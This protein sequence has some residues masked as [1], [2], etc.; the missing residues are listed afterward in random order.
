[1]RRDAAGLRFFDRRSRECDK[2]ETVSSP[3]SRRETENAAEQNQ[4]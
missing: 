1:M 2:S 4:S 3:R